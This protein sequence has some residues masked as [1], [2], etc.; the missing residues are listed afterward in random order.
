MKRFMRT[1]GKEGEKRKTN[2]NE[3]K[4]TKNS[5]ESSSRNVH[6]KKTSRHPGRNA[7]REDEKKKAVHPK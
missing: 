7:L 6:G 2:E 3:T 4:F 1:K 5:A